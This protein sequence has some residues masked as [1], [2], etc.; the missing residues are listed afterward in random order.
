MNESNDKETLKYIGTVIKAKR[1][2]AGKTQEQLA[3]ALGVA[4]STISKY[5]HGCINI[6]LSTLPRI[7]NICNFPLLDYVSIKQKSLD[8]ADFLVRNYYFP[9]GLRTGSVKG[10]TDDPVLLEESLKYSETGTLM[11]YFMKNEAE[12]N[13][14]LSLKDVIISNSAGPLKDAAD[15]LVAEILS[16]ECDEE[17]T[18]L[19][20]S[21]IAKFKAYNQIKST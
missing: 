15:N 11:R 14:I 4:K 10:A 8:A 13:A 3:E 1:K 9:D 20:R 12:A 5:E 7:S 18:L 17:G 6:P 19:T 16:K 2:K 21:Y